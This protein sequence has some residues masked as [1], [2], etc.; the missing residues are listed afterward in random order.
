MPDTRSHRGPHPEDDALFAQSAMPELRDAAR[1]LAWL[2][3]RGYGDNAA[4]KLVGDRYQLTRRQRNA[5]VRS[6]CSDVAAA[7]RGEA[8][9]PVTAIGGRPVHIDGFN[10]LI[11]LESALGGA[12]LFVGRDE[13]YRDIETLHGTYRLVVETESAIR[14]MG[15][16]LDALGAGVVTWH[17]DA[18][19]SNTGRLRAR[20]LD[21]AKSEEWRWVVQQE[22]APDD[23]LAAV[24]NGVVITHD[25]G[26]LD[27]A[28]AWVSLVGFIVDRHVPEA[29][30]RR[31]DI[32][33]PAATD[34]SSD[35]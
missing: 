13:C 31:L 14:L 10:V 29:K 20:L 22:D 3:T 33:R 18:H 24:E 28:A 15:S 35:V 26:I 2:R 8:Q 12:Y 27:R 4:L 25:S 11:A 17:L 1:D 16:T 9:R 30:V 32:E 21:A 19:V 7:R 5:L 34:Q 23:R 6:A